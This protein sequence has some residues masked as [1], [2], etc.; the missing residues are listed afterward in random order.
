MLQIAGI[1]KGHFN[2]IRIIGLQLLV[3][4][5]R[6]QLDHLLPGI[7]DAYPRG[8]IHHAIIRFPANPGVAADS[9]LPPF[10]KL[11]HVFPGCLAPAFS[12]K[13]QITSSFTVP[14][15]LRFRNL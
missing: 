7:T 4:L 14:V 2:I 1:V 5:F 6:S 9:V 11:I 8:M 13:P 12:S 10:Q 15:I 3:C